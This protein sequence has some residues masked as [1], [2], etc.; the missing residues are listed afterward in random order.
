[1]RVFTILFGVVF[2]IALV[3]TLSVWSLV[4]FGVYTAV[5]NPEAIGDHIARGVAPII[6]VVNGEN[7]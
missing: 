4:G 6:E 5:T 3:G 7:E 2:T 1:M